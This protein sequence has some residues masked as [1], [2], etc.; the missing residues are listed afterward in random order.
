MQV[1]N[2]HRGNYQDPDPY[3]QQELVG[4]LQTR[5]SRIERHIRGVKK[6]LDEGRDCGD[7]L[8]Q[9]AGVDAALRQPAIKLLEGRLETGLREE[10]GGSGG[11]EA[12]GRF[13]TSMSRVLKTG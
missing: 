1:M 13:K 9:V 5:L 7:I 8:T 3:L 4:D 11:D 6:M 12:V 10:I 2:A